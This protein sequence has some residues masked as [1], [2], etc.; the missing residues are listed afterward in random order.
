MSRK[1]LSKQAQTKL[2]EF[3]GQLKKAN[4]IASGLTT[5]QCPL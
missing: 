5:S 3:R 4:E 1:G 2:A